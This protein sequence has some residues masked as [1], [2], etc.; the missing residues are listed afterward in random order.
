MGNS[1]IPAPKLPPMLLAP[2]C[3]SC[4]AE[5]K[6]PAEFGTTVNRV[7]NTNYCRYCYWKG[8]FTHPDITMEEQIEKAAKLMAM[9][10]RISKERALQ[11]AARTIPKLSRWKKEEKK[12]DKA[13]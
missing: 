10:K 1:T 13:E 7:I 6:K 8:E 11:I 3:Q 9:K 4:G 12:E 5:M 2:S